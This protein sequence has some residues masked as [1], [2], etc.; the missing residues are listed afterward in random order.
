MPEITTLYVA[1]EEAE[2]KYSFEGSVISID[3][4]I[5]SQD[6]L[7]HLNSI[8][9]RDKH[10]FNKMINLPIYKSFKSEAINVFNTKVHSP[11]AY[12]KASEYANKLVSSY[13]RIHNRTKLSYDINKVI[14]SFLY[15]TGGILKELLHY[16]RQHYFKAQLDLIENFNAQ[17]NFEGNRII[18][19]CYDFEKY[20]HSFGF[21]KNYKRIRYALSHSGFHTYSLCNFDDVSIKSKLFDM[22]AFNNKDA[23]HKQALIIDRSH[24]I[25]NVFD[26][27]NVDKVYIFGESTDSIK[28][29]IN[30]DKYKDTEFIKVEFK[31]DE[32]FI[33]SIT[34]DPQEIIEYY[35]KSLDFEKLHKRLIINS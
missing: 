33:N 20:N 10:I 32:E 1:S 11:T 8:Y 4:I 31:N 23:S 30:F 21:E 13:R 22:M 35:K 14:F 27:K 6:F 15:P 24:F 17:Y 18:V 5:N 16:I 19:I 34:T 26:F 29:N 25:T 9:E 12:D 7:S 3:S 2:K 28:K